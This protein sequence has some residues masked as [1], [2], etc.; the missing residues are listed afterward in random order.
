MIL[1]SLRIAINMLRKNSARV[2]MTVF[3]ITIG[4]A[5]VI[6]VFSAGTGVKGLILGQLSSFGDNWIN[7][8]VKVPDMG[9]NASGRAIAQGVNITTLTTKD[10][11]SIRKLSTVA[12]LYAGVS[13]QAIISYKDTKD[14]P[15]I[16][17]VS[18]E[19]PFIDTGKIATGRFF[20]DAEDAGADTV[21][22]L[23]SD[24][25]EKLFGN[26]NPLNTTVK[27]DSK[28]Y[29]VIGVMEKRGVTGFFNF[30]KVIFIPLTTVQKKIMGIDHVSWIIAQTYTNSQSE[31]TA[32]E[33]RS[34]LRERHDISS[35]SKDDFSVT[36]MTESMDIINTVF[37]GITW[38]LIALAAISLLVGGVGIMN[39][40]YVSVVERTF[41]IG[42]RKAVGASRRD[43]LSQ[44]LT[45][46][47]VITIFGGCVGILIG[48]LISYLIALI[49]RTIG[50]EWVF[51]ISA[52]SMIIAVGFSTGVGL[53]FG[54]YPARQAASLNPIDAIR[55]E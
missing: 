47:V 31:D 54:L 13:S 2:F 5:M 50:Y 42:L 43:I 33:I 1:T 14:R 18:S 12:H 23:G 4:I 38:L 9:Q 53:L 22:V 44:F 48:I 46:A 52:A 41:E 17:G 45:E 8:E 40:M 24:V 32:D 7:I 36:T 28:T 26:E 25:A 15:M 21:V 27:I 37:L 10:A 55:Q 39:V 34:L 35:P 29:R 49:A 3:G 51:S 6:I 20:T 30:D 19:Y 16:F 11:E